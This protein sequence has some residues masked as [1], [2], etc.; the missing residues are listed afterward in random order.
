MLGTLISALR[1]AEIEEITD[2]VL[3]SDHGQI[4]V[5]RLISPNVYLR[6]AGY[7]TL[8][9]GGELKD[10]SAFAKQSGGSAQIYLKNPDDK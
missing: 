8:G 1:E 2:I 10:W 9:E 4:G 3:L 7:I 5:T 6:R